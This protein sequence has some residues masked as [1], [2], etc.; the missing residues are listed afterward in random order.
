MMLVFVFSSLLVLGVYNPL[1]PFILIFLSIT[2][3]LLFTTY[4]I[5]GWIA[6]TLLFIYSTSTA[7]IFYCLIHLYKKY[8]SSMLAYAF[9]VI[10]ILL[11]FSFHYS[12]DTFYHAYSLFDSWFWSHFDSRLDSSLFKLWSWDNF[13]TW[14][15]FSSWNDFNSWFWNSFDNGPP[16]FLLFLIYLSLTFLFITVIL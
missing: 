2:S 9:L 4:V 14:S 15:N 10:L 16:D 13:P 3:W 11:I 7:I 8:F 1:I 6:I 12:Q 5:S